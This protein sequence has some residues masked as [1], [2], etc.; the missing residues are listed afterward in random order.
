VIS[1]LELCGSGHH[2]SIRTASNSSETFF[3]LLS[4]NWCNRLSQSIH[5]WSHGGQ[6]QFYRWGLWLIHSCCSWHSWLLLHFHSFCSMLLV[7]DLRT[8]RLSHQPKV[9][10]GLV[11]ET[12]LSLIAIPFFQRPSSIDNWSIN[13]GLASPTSDSS[14]WFDCLWKLNW[15]CISRFWL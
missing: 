3:L 1:L 5:P 13:S 2:L 15:L 6:C 9:Y 14:F 8:E 4:R 7:L 11:G 12:V 10:F